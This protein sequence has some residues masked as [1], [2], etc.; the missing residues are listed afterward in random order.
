[1]MGRVVVVVVK[2]VVVAVVV[3]VE[4]TVVEVEWGYGGGSG[5]GGMEAIM[6][7][8]GS[9]RQLSPRHIQQRPLL[10]VYFVSVYPDEV[11]AYQCC[12]LHSLL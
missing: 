10:P 6:A 5:S 8:G 2:E 11:A 7:E 3:E 12:L 9:V 1:M 4:V